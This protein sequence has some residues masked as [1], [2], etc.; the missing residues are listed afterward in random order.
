MTE[1]ANTYALSGQTALVTGGSRGIGRGIAVGLARCGANVVV[2]YRDA[3]GAAAQVVAEIER[4]GRKGLA[5]RADVTDPRAV[6]RMLTEMES[7]VG[8]A[9]ILV[10]KAGVIPRTPVLQNS[11]GEWS[12][13]PQSQPH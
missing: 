4:Y 12:V 6:D 13:G 2:N 3:A 8:P 7:A 10:H 11:P 9:E 1:P 5:L